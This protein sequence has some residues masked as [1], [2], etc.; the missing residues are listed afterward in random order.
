M[1][2]SLG[3]AVDPP[4]PVRQRRRHIR[5]LG[6]EARHPQQNRQ[7]RA[8]LVAHDADERLLERIALAQVL[9]H[10]RQLIVLFL[11]LAQQ[12]VSLDDQVIMLHRLTNDRLQFIRI[13]RLGNVAVNVPLIDCVDHRAQVGVTGKQETNRF[14]MIPADAIEELHA[15]HL[16][17]AL[18][19]H[20]D[21]HF[22]ALHE[23]EALSRARRAEHLVV[24][25]Q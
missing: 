2:Q 13:P 7:R 20:D 25:A 19:A 16:R 23:P 17:H 24:K 8:Q 21:V 4:Q 18:V 6:G 11:Q 1:L 22:L 12:P 3:R 15:G 10:L 5:L 9:V 14:R